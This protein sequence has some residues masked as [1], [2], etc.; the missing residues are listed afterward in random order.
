[1]VEKWES[2]DVKT[3]QQSRIDIRAHKES[4]VKSIL[5]SAQEGML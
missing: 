1:M 3:L 4:L 2:S 5:H